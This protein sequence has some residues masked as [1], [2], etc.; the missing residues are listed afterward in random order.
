MIS[1]FNMHYFNKKYILFL[2]L[3]LNLIFFSTIKVQ[4]NSF[5]INNIEIS[6]PFENNFD[7]RTV[8]IKDSRSL[9]GI[10]SSLIKSDDQ[11]KIKNV[12]L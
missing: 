12:K 11:T 1:K 8:M 2:F 3:S 10:S 9:F 4:A 5:E 6:R 7:K